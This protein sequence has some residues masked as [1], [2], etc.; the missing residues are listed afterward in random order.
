MSEKDIQVNSSKF[1]SFRKS[2]APSTKQ[3][4]G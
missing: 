3:H 2:I 4:V 1:R